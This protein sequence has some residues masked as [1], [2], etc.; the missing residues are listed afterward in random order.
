MRYLKHQLD[1]QMAE[2]LTQFRNY[3][4]NHYILQNQTNENARKK[5]LGDYNRIVTHHRDVFHQYNAVLLWCAVLDTADSDG[6]NELKKGFKKLHD[7]HF[8]SYIVQAEKKADSVIDTLWSHKKKL[9]VTFKQEVEGLTEAIQQHTQTLEQFKQEAKPLVEPRLVLT[10]TPETFYTAVKQIRRTALDV[11]L[12]VLNLK[13]PVVATHLPFEKTN[14]ITCN[15]R[16]TLLQLQTHINEYKAE[17]DKE[18]LFTQFTRFFSPTRWRRKRALAEYEAT[19]AVFSDREINKKYKAAEAW[20]TR[21]GLNG[22]FDEDSSSRF[23][24]VCLAPFHTANAQDYFAQLDLP[25]QQQANRLKSSDEE[26]ANATTTHNKQVLAL[27]ETLRDLVED[28]EELHVHTTHFIREATAIPETAAAYVNHH[29]ALAQSQQE[30]REIVYELTQK[31]EVAHQVVQD[32]MKLDRHPSKEAITQLNLQQRLAAI[33]DDSEALAIIHDAVQTLIDATQQSGGKGNNF[34]FLGTHAVAWIVEILGTAQQKALLKKERPQAITQAKVLEQNHDA[35]KAD[36]LVKALQGDLLTGVLETRLDR[37]RDAYERH[38]KLYGK[39]PNELSE[40]IYEE[41]IKHNMR[42]A[43]KCHQ[44]G[45]Q[46]LAHFIQDI[47]GGT[48]NASA[49]AD[50]DSMKLKPQE[51]LHPE[52]VTMLVLT[53]GTEQQIKSWEKNLLPRIQA[54]SRAAYSDF[55]TQRMEP[56]PAMRHA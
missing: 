55:H 26:I 9:A 45:S 10:A 11:Q 8:K 3:L 39:V 2:L 56:A 21:H 50:R 19:V 33:Q 17:W 44:S 5:A 18:S 13:P 41:Q 40:K 22:E 31:R 35:Q 37:W 38:K 16:E 27:N 25:N 6:F 48:A 7:E 24:Q 47:M 20:F 1:D 29:K 28:Q 34:K 30:I 15:K 42:Q 23:Y 14:L 36:R 43:K 52:N 54:N 49:Y 51:C 53:F 32:L 4:F 12:P 46:T